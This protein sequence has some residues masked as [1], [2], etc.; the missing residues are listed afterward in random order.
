MRLG[1]DDTPLPTREELAKIRW[2]PRPCVDFLEH[3]R[4]SLERT[5]PLLGEEAALALQNDGA[6]ANRKILSALG[7][8]PPDDGAVDWSS[9]FHRYLPAEPASLNPIFR[10]SAYDAYFVELLA[11]FPVEYDWEFRG[12]G[13]LDIIESWEVS[14]DRLMDR[15]VLRKDLTW[16]DGK[17]VT[18]H[19]VEFTW[20]LIMDNRS[21]L[22]PAQTMASG[23]R[24]V[25]AHDDRTVVYFQKEALATN[26][27]H[28][29]WPILPRH[30]YAPLRE[31]DPTLETHPDCVAANTQP[32][33]CGPYRLVSWDRGASII[34]D[35]RREWYEASNGA[36]IRQKPYFERVHFHLKRDKTSAFLSFLAGEIDD[37]E[38]D[39]GQWTGGTNDARFRAVGTKVRG[40]KWS[41]GY[42]GWNTKSLPPNPFFGDRRV[43]LA[44]THAVDHAHMLET[45][46][47]GLCS[48]GRGVFHPASPWAA[49]ELKPFQF[50]LALSERLLEEAGW[51]DSD[52]DGIRDKSIEGKLV[53]FE[54]NLCC[55]TEGESG[56]RVAEDLQRNLRRIGVLCSIQSMEWNTFNEEVIA[57]KP[58]AFI[59][60]LITGSDPDTLKNFWSTA[61]S[62][63][64][65]NY[66]GYSSAKVDELIEKGRRELDFSKRVK[67][68][69]EMDLTIAEDHP[70]TPLCYLPTQWAFSKRLR[71]FCHSPRGFY[72][73]APGFHSIW[74]K[75]AP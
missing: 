36:R 66:V 62:K 5:P 6:E 10:S 61:A 4:A 34:L 23:L 58:Q 31:K 49:P 39:S 24:A 65:R 21:R 38:L 75:K 67:V 56:R 27:T 44:M 11:V 13:N 17:S 50:D 41:N 25:K 60:A 8:F 63:D 43:R 16:S 45:I 20:N 9:T 18:A 40:E 64:G 2:T 48:P 7:G 26:P 59:M 72:G 71:G 52:G 30:I 70:I 29:S 68:Y 55:P 73:H 1:A 54:F 42:I 46:F 74:R 69:Q 51:K 3:L 53:K 35:R 28:L 33:T 37:V 22:K 14:E 47:H 15:I 12:Y 19:D 32:V 57:R